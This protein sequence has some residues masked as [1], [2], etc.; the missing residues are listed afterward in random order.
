MIDT[1]AY[2]VYFFHYRHAC[3]FSTIDMLRVFVSIELFCG[4]VGL[5]Y[6]DPGLFNSDECRHACCLR[7]FV[8][9]G[10]FCEDVG[11]LCGDVWRYIH[12][13]TYI[14]TYFLSQ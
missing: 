12:I 14:Y 3:S 7:G 1:R 13:Y 2:S 5:F 9:V 8:D 10:L 6:G 11:L 4:D